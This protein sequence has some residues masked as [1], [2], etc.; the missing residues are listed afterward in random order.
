MLYKHLFACLLFF[1]ILHLSCACAD[2]RPPKDAVPLSS[3][4]K[5]LEDKGYSPVTEVALEKDRWE[6]E[7]YRDGKARELKVN[8][9][10]KEIISDRAD[11]YVLIVPKWRGYR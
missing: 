7:A 11:D 1:A 5:S 4:V 6:I 8:P 9:V 10:S 3:I 2:E